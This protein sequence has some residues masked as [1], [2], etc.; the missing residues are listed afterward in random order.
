MRDLFKMSTKINIFDLCRTI[1]NEE[2][3]VGGPLQHETTTQEVD[4]NSVSVKALTNDE[5]EQA[6]GETGADGS[7]EVEVENDN[8]GQL[9]TSMEELEL[10]SVESDV[11]SDVEDVEDGFQDLEQTETT[12]A[13]LESYYQLLGSMDKKGYSVSK[14]TATSIRIGLEAFGIYD[15]KTLVVS[16]EEEKEKSSSESSMSK[17]WKKIKELMELARR[18]IVK[19]IDS[20]LNFWSSLINGIG[21]VRKVLLKAEAKRQKQNSHGHYKINAKSVS[22]MLQTSTNASVDASSIAETVKIANSFYTGVPSALYDTANTLKPMLEDYITEGRSGDVE[23]GEAMGRV[24]LALVDELKAIF[25]DRSEENSFMSKE[26]LG[27]TKIKVSVGD[28]GRFKQFLSNYG[29][30]GSLLSFSLERVH[31]NNK[32]SVGKEDVLDFSPSEVKSLI[33]EGL[34][35]LKVLEEGAEYRKEAK[36][37]QD[38]IKR[39]VK[40][41]D[42]KNSK[43]I[44]EK[45]KANMLKDAVRGN[46]QITGHVFRV[47]KAIATLVNALTDATD[48]K[49]EEAN[50]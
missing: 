20:A 4:N 2:S 7:D 34:N 50:A 37:L 28:I 11:V 10:Q 24:Q 12:I 8:D 41:S 42:I 47:A 29:L 1:S 39:D 26:L 38:E 33:K 19:V 5:I 25:P 3:S 14:E 22:P 15:S 32:G 6:D 17:I 27:S 21:S 48:G 13:A 45:V 35:I 49:K 9:A 44:F 43:V 16:V 36:K 18:I 31:E 30:S 40:E 23:I 46:V